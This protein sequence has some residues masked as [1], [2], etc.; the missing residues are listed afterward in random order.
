MILR[1]LKL[2][3]LQQCLSFNNGC[4]KPLPHDIYCYSSFHPIQKT[5]WTLCKALTKFASSLLAKAMSHHIYVLLP[6]KWAV[7]RQYI[8]E[9]STTI[10]CSA[11]DG[12]EATSGTGISAVGSL[13]NNSSPLFRI[14]PLMVEGLLFTAK[15]CCLKVYTTVI[16]CDS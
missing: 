4:L 3:Q 14:H 12:S 7:D 15:P 6:F 11:D 1:T 9:G 16:H 10:H 13:R 5:N 8:N 2:L